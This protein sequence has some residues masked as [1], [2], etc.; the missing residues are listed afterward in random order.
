MP[1]DDMPD[2]DHSPGVLWNHRK[3]RINKRLY[4]AACVFIAAEYIRHPV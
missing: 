3:Q 2:E 4:L 1:T